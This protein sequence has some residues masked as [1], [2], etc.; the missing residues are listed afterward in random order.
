MALAIDT[1]DGHLIGRTLRSNESHR[2]GNAA[3]AIHFTV[4]AV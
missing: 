4:K 3:F 2:D 1:I